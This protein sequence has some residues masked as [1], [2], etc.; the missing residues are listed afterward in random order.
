MKEQH[1]TWVYFSYLNFYDLNS[2]IKVPVLL[3]IECAIKA[4]SDKQ[5]L[6]AL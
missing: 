5:N 2:L 1:P 3:L 4:R 6:T